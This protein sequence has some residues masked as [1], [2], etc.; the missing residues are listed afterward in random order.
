MNELDEA[1]RRNGKL[2]RRMYA[3]RKKYVAA[4]NRQDFYVFRGWRA[5]SGHVL[6][7]RHDGCFAQIDDLGRARYEVRR[8]KKR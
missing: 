6:K 2:L 8:E 4:Y 1:N 7:R 5:I 3:A